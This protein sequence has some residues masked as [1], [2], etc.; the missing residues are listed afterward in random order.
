MNETR[1]LIC[2]YDRCYQNCKVTRAPQSLA[3][4]S[5]PNVLRWLCLTSSMTGIFQ[6]NFYEEIK[7]QTYQEGS[8]QSQQTFNVRGLDC[9][10]GP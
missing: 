9:P 1:T 2:V 4:T 6:K 10:V 7:A 3:V 8:L 5:P